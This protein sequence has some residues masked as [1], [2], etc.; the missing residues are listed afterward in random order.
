MDGIPWYWDMRWWCY[1][2]QVRIY[3]STYLGCNN[4]IR[5]VS[6]LSINQA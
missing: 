2:M 6:R 3:L 1:T 5:E 4:F